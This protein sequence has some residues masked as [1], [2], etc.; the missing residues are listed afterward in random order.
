MGEK[1]GPGPDSKTDPCAPLG[2]GN[3]LSIYF[4]M[5]RPVSI[6]QYACLGCRLLGHYWAG[7]L[8]A[9]D[10]GVGLFL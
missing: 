4:L 8:L 5:V 9:L 1:W 10:S 7:L 3:F 6:D 2:P